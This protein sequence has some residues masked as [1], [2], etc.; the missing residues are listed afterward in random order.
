VN[1]CET[2]CKEQPPLVTTAFD[3]VE[4]TRARE[5]TALLSMCPKEQ[6]HV[7]TLQLTVE[8]SDRAVAATR[9]LLLVGSVACRH[10]R[11]HKLLAGHCAT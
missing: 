1:F 2:A 5:V 9:D 8:S 10:V 7:Y 4:L 6:C 3:K 11:R